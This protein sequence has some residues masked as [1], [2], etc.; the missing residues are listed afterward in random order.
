MKIFATGSDRAWRKVNSECVYVISRA[1]FPE[2]N[3]K[4]CDGKEAP[5]AFV[6]I[7]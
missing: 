7:H 4:R 2:E 5:L 6:S 1:L 3:L